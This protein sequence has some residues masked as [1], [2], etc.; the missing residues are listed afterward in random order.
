[1]ALLGAI[2]LTSPL[3]IN[4]SV[5]IILT[6]LFLLVVFKYDIIYFIYC[7]YFITLNLVAFIPYIILLIY[8]GIDVSSTI[9]CGDDHSIRPTPQDIIDQKIENP[10]DQDSRDMG[11]ITK[12]TAIIGYY[13]NHRIGMDTAAFHVGEVDLKFREDMENHQDRRQAVEYTNAIGNIVAQ[14]QDSYK[15]SIVNLQAST[16]PLDVLQP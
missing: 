16:D 12:R 14:I 5:A 11:I 15:Q 7:H 13:N 1:M 9:C 4:L 6:L 2:I 10:F 8:T 3:K